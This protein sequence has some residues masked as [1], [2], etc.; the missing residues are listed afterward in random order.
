MDDRW[1]ALEAHLPEAE[2]AVA[3]AAALL[4]KG[5]GQVAGHQAVLV[6][7]SSHRLPCVLK[8]V[9]RLHSHSMCKRGGVQPG[10]LRL[11][12]PKA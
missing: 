12:R 7:N 6:C 10:C 11:M 9:C 3:P 2:V 8:V 4:G 5:Q 1:D